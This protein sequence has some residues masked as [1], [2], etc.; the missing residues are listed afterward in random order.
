LQ[1]QPVVKYQWSIEQL[2]CRPKDRHPQRAELWDWIRQ[3]SVSVWRALEEHGIEV[4]TFFRE[5]P[6]K[7]AK[8]LFERC[9]LNAERSALHQE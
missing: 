9:T 3:R 5:A 4:S 6:G 8:T 2:M 1:G 7:A